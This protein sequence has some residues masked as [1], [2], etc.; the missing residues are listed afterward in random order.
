MRTSEIRGAIR[1][2]GHTLESL[3]IA[4]GKAPSTISNWL[5]GKTSMTLDDAMKMSS[6]LDLE[7]HPEFFWAMKWILKPLCII[8]TLLKP[9]NGTPER[10]SGRERRCNGFLAVFLHWREGSNP[11]RPFPLSSRGKHQAGPP[12]LRN[13]GEHLNYH[14]RA[15]RFFLPLLSPAGPLLIF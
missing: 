1:A 10:R 13:G 14:F 6:L 11:P 9:G 4:L 15:G 5:S 12:W 3:A 7:D 8:W 2:K